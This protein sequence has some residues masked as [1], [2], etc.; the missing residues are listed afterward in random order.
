MKKTLSP[1]FFALVAT[2]LGQLALFAEITPEQ[3]LNAFNGAAQ[4]TKL[5]YHWDSFSGGLPV[6]ASTPRTL[7]P[8]APSLQT[9]SWDPAGQ[10]SLYQQK[11]IGSTTYNCTL[12]GTFTK[13]NS[14]WDA[15]PGTEKHLTYDSGGTTHY[16]STWV[17]SGDSLKNYLQGN[18]FNTAS[19]PPPSSDTSLR[20]SQSLGTKPV[21]LDLKGLAFFWVPLENLARPAYSQDITSQ[22]P[23]LTTWP[24]GTYQSTETGSPAGFNYVDYGNDT[25]LYTG[26]SGAATF[27]EYTQAQTAYP[28]TAMGYTYNWNFLQD[29]STPDY[30]TDPNRVSS[31]I[32]LTE[33]LVSSDTSI[34]LDQ[35]IPYSEL[36]AWVV[37]EPSVFFLFSAGILFLA[38]RPHRQHTRS[39][40]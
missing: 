14:F 9:L 22:L 7:L 2:L 38:L 5:S 39:P 13:P 11:T 33:F 29:G 8:T 31:P 28:W 36:G 34:L 26:A 24:D 37:P 16:I 20:I 12:V 35:W 21:Q 6:V 40:K 30:G 27:V 19:P 25:I 4:T 10:P 1:L 15:A 32:A 18:Y 17:T 23:S 3:Q